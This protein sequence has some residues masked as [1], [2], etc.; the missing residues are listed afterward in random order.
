MKNRTGDLLIQIISVTVGVFL[1]FVISSWSE[2]KRET[3]KHNI[4]LEAIEAEIQANRDKVKDVIDYHVLVRDSSRHYLT[5]VNSG[6]ND[7]SYFKGINT[8]TFEN[9]AYQTG[10][11]SGLF[12]TNNL[13]KIQ[14]INDIYTKQ[15]SYEDFT[16]L[17]LSGLISMDF[18]ETEKSTRKITTF[19][20]IG[21]TDVV[22]KE[23]DLLKSYDTALDIIQ[24]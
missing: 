17:M 14:A 24:E 19:L 16:I 12:G 15:R 13:K 1:G 4:I 3:R 20:S 22:I 8:I 21:M 6:N 5:K 18:E 7:L 2:N 9:S 23:Q 10:I 11:Q